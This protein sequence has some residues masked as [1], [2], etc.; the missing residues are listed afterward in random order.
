MTI[1]AIVVDVL[2]GVM[3]DD[4]DTLIAEVFN[5]GYGWVERAADSGGEA[6]K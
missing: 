5:C 3:D 4:L 6:P 2:Q 1:E